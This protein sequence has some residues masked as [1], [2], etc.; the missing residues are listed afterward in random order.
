MN[1]GDDESLDLAI[2]DRNITYP[3]DFYL[4]RGTLPGGV[5]GTQLLRT[6]TQYFWMEPVGDRYALY[7]RIASQLGINGDEALKMMEEWVSLFALKHTG[8]KDAWKAEA[9]DGKAR[10]IEANENSTIV[11]DISGHCDGTSTRLAHMGYTWDVDH[12]A[13]AI[14]AATGDN[15]STEKMLETIQRKRLLEH[16]YNILCENMIGEFS[17]PSEATVE[18][19]TEPVSNGF[20]SGKAWDE[21]GSEQVG[22]EYCEIRGCDPETGIPELDE[23]NRLGLDDMAN[24]LKGIGFYGETEVIQEQTSE[25]SNKRKR[26]NP[27]KKN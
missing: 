22:R 9:T 15:I 6:T 21:S 19:L 3:V 8:K 2:H 26:K 4:E 14:S 20:F 27:K 17:L 18:V 13:K 16:S 23:L 7:Q 1:L 10:Y 24:K 11:S 25:L 12:T 5:G